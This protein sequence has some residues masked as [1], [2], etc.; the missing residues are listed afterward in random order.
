MNNKFSKE[1]ANLNVRTKRKGFIIGFL[2]RDKLKEKKM[3][4]RELTNF[5][6]TISL[7]SILNSLHCDSWTVN[8]LLS[9]TTHADSISLAKRPVRNKTSGF[10]N[11]S[12]I[13]PSSFPQKGSTS[14]IF[15]K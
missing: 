4:M 11:H 3:R 6:E 10:N 12:R 2:G 13:L 7:E 14:C 15:D 8:N 5:D 9:M 1:Y